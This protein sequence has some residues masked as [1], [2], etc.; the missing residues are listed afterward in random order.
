[1]LLSLL[2]LNTG[3]MVF[4]DKYDTKISEQDEKIESI[5]KETKTV[6]A[7]KEKTDKQI[8]EVKK[9]V[10]AIL[11]EKNEKEQKMN[12]YLED[13]KELE[14][15]IERRKEILESQ[16]REM[17]VSDKQNDVISILLES[18]SI[19]D[20]ISRS[21]GAAKI[22][23]AGNDIMQ[24]QIAD[25]EKIAV[26]K[27]ELEVQLEEIEAHTS[28]L[29]AKQQELVDLRVNQEVEIAN[30]KLKLNTEVKEK[31]KLQQAKAK[32][33]AK[34]KAYLRELERQRQEEARL[35]AE[36]AQQGQSSSGSSQITQSATASKGWN[37]P[38]DS[39]YV[40]TSGFGS[41]VDPTGASGTQHDG[42]DLAGAAGSPI[43]SSLAGTVVEAGYHYSAGNHVVIQHANGL[44]T[45]YMHMNASPSVSVGQQVGAK[46]YLGG[47]GTTGN[48]TGV[49]LHFGVSTGLWSGFQNP[50]NYI[51]F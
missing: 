49:H 45:Y 14:V 19:T 10:S 32:A 13:I 7:L 46:E 34:R 6:K 44:Y 22:L 42:I 39:S 40:I 3:T 35:E 2:L 9:E 20:F 4:A 1:M 18:D 38:L 33:V 26:I 27:E 43:Y 16:A 11:K 28:E 51:S 24:E 8:A 25:K 5:Q 50:M 12:Q 36:Q 21:I 30:L 37:S 17:Q 23:T 47:M 48:S 31:K 15:K 41:R 29:K